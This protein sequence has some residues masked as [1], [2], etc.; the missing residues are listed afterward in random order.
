MDKMKQCQDVLNNYNTVDFRLITYFKWSYKF[1]SCLCRK[2]AA[3]HEHVLTRCRGINKSL[4]N[5]SSVHLF[6]K[7]CQYYTK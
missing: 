5:P 2:E 6:N 7:T 4:L 3:M 1:S